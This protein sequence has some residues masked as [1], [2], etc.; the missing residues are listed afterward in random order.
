L[1]GSGKPSWRRRDLCLNG[2]IEEKYLNSAWHQVSM[3]SMLAV[4]TAVHS[5]W[6]LLNGK[7][8]NK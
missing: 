6:A 5:S 4:V 2:L 8:Y 1:E 3:H 7:D